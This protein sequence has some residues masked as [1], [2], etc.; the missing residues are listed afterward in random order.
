MTF[1]NKAAEEF[2]IS[3]E[4][5]FGRLVKLKDVICFKWALSSKY[6]MEWVC[7]H[8]QSFFMKLQ[9]YWNMQFLPILNS[10]ELVHWVVYELKGVML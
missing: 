2:G 6:R 9:N 7:H 3:K 1:G 10:S 8:F 4:G 5:E